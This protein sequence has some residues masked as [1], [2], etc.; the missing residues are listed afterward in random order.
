MSRRTVAVILLAVGF[1]GLPANAYIGPGAGFAI[2]GSFMVFFLAIVAAFLAVLIF[3]VRAVVRMVQVRRQGNHPFVKRVIILGLDGMDP[4]LAE[5][6]MAEGKMPN[7]KRLA[8]QGCFRRLK[9][10]L[11]AMS[12]VAW[13]TFATGVNPGKHNIFDFLMP[14]R[15]TNLP[16]LSSTRIREPERTLKLG[17][18]VIPLQRPSIQLLR[19]SQP[20][21]KILGEHWI[22]SHVLRVPITF[23]PEKFYGAELSAMCVPDLRGTQGS[24]TCW[25]TERSGAKPTG[26][27]ELV[28]SKSDDGFRGFI[29]GPQNTLSASREELVLPF[30][31]KRG[32]DG[33]WELCLQGH[34][35]PLAEK[36]Y[37]EWVRLKFKAAPGVKVSGLAKFMLLK[38]GDA[39]ELYMTP[40]NLDPENPAMPV[41]HPGFFSAYLA[42]L[43][44]PFA[45]LGL[46]EDTWA[47]N[48]RVLDEDAFLK[49]A[50]DFYE[51]REKLFFHCLSRTRQGALVFVFDHTDRIQHTF[52]RCLDPSHPLYGS[53]E[54]EKYRG[55][56]EEVY[57]RADELLGRVLARLGRGD[58]LMVMSDHGF[59]SFRRGLNLNSWL[60][61]QGY[62]VCQNGSGSAEMFKDVDWSRTRAYAL[63]LSGIYLNL[64]GREARGIVAP[65]GEA[66]ALRKE[67]AQKLTGLKDPDTGETAV[68]RGYDAYESLHGPYL[69]NAPDVL[70]GYNAGYRMDWEGTLGSASARIFSDN[71]KSWSGDH[72]IDPSCVPGVLFTN[73]RFSREDAWI[74]DIAPTVLRLFDLKVPAYMDG[75]PLLN[76]QEL[77]EVRKR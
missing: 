66:A 54:A 5:K 37:S 48:E 45:T 4:E 50:W 17:K 63:G 34:K 73:F 38:A 29:P 46:A 14:D 58:A 62:L 77:E 51:E 36:K 10:T 9:T 60:L 55:A 15:K 24:F 6:F 12:P 52:F 25:R 27:M 23:P 67:I 74:G 7:F 72:C 53:A 35:L 2:L 75:K 76:D 11:P 22:F 49:Q 64:K 57:L 68:L 47:L 8:E 59:K 43:F 65:G 13:S 41:S 71:L 44:G 40:L 69:E 70:V 18:Y 33:G 30:E 3:P 42:K 1:L 32:A 28:L 21:W 19:K 20:F 31:L 39:P 26:G 16:V 56:I 61:Q